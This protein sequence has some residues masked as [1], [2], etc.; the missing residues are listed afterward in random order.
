[1]NPLMIWLLGACTPV[2][3]KSDDTA[4]DTAST[5][6]ACN[7]A[8]YSGDTASNTGADSV[9]GLWPVAQV[10]AQ[11][12]TPE[13]AALVVNTDGTGVIEFTQSYFVMQTIV[14]TFPVTFRSASGVTATLLP[15]TKSADDTKNVDPLI[16][17]GAQTVTIAD[18]DLNGLTYP[19]DTITNSAITVNGGDLTL[20]NVFVADVQ[21]G[22]VATSSNVILE[23]V[24]FRD[25]VESAISLTSGTAELSEVEVSQSG[26]VD[27]VSVIS[28][29]SDTDVT[30]SGGITIT[31][32][33]ATGDQ[34]PLI[35]LSTASSIESLIVSDSESTS[36]PLANLTV[37]TAGDYGSLTN[38]LFFDNTYGDDCA[39]NLTGKGNLSMDHVIV[40]DL[41]NP[42]SSDSLVCLSPDTD[43]SVVV[44]NSILQ[45]NWSVTGSVLSGLSAED[46]DQG[47]VRYNNFYDNEGEDAGLL[48]P[49]N[50]S[51][52]P[53]FSNTV[54]ADC[55]PY[56]FLLA[57]DSTLV[58][59]G[60]PAE[61]DN[62]GSQTDMGAF[63]GEGQA[64][65][66]TS[67]NWY[68]GL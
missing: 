34:T 65:L 26:G 48:D 19:G 24:R 56:N 23:N 45:R 55:K 30:V 7:M 33:L 28:A 8:N 4:A 47:A 35:E 25:A 15:G 39:I 43:G 40:S 36:G 5:S 14:P 60:D 44:E 3:N 62:D 61:R 41:D 52:D 37:G 16:D 57:I 66:E 68:C 59:A 1:M 18:L 51:E 50:V 54:N 11:C 9:T 22:V 31:D 67:I 12:P 13:D 27:G 63:G 17:V 46:Y 21:S 32:S 64:N 49:T 29:T 20:T 2:T 38:S 58:D 6:T 10:P 53:N 42:G